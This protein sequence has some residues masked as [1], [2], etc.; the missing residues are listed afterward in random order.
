VTNYDLEELKAGVDELVTTLESAMATIEK[1][2]SENE[3]L[4]ERVMEL[5]K[6]DKQLAAQR[7]TIAT[8]RA[9]KQRGW[10][11][12]MKGIRGERHKPGSRSHCICTQCRTRIF[13][14][15]RDPTG[16]VSYTT[17]TVTENRIA[18]IRNFGALP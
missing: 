18:A 15:M 11:T 6:Q 16:G 1:L 17:K 12:V 9:R 8:L 5:F 2:E 13:D 7:R 3:Q 14:V 10:H 4:K